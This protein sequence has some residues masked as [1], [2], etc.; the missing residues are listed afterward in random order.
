MVSPITDDRPPRIVVAP[1]APEEATALARYLSVSPLVGRLLWNRGVRDRA[2]ATSFLT[3]RLS[4]LV[5]PDKLP[6]MGLAAAR[7]AKA[8]RSGEP[9]AVCGD[10]DV[11][12][13]TGTALLI[14][15]LRLAGGT[16]SYAIPDREAD[17][18]GLSVKTVE[19]LAA[20]GVKLLITVDNGVGAVEPLERAKALGI[21]AIVTD[22]HLPGPVLPPAVAIVD[23]HRT[24]GPGHA[25]SHLCGCGLAFKLAWGDLRGAPARAARREAEDVP[26]RRDGPRRARDGGRRDAADGR[27]PRARR[28]GADGAAREQVARASA[29]CST[30][31][32]CRPRRSRQRTSRGSWRR[33]STPRGE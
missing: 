4:D 31:R 18:Y 3:P 5:L 23:P 12:G 24:D 10:Y 22:H 27:E 7:V 16:V 1:A 15:F 25:A 32:G 2:T 9:I 8:V 19:R 26:A 13:M 29:P 17:G 28:G 20:E 14:R 33:G 11:D 6:D 30:S 21:D